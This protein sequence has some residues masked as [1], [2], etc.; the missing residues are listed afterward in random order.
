MLLPD[1]IEAVKIAEIRHEDLGLDHIVK[2]TSRG[3]ERLG[4]AFQDVIGL[5]LDVRAIVGKVHIA[6][7]DRRNRAGRIDCALA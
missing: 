1:L 3:L 6:A 7:S 2:G 5:K 4:Q